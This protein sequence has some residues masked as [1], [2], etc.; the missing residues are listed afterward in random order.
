MYVLYHAGRLPE[1]IADDQE[2]FRNLEILIH[3]RVPPLIRSLPHVESLS[4]FRAEESQ[5]EADV[6]KELGLR[7][8]VPDQPLSTQDT[9]DVVMEE[10]LRN[11]SA[12]TKDTTSATATASSSLPT[13]PPSIP[14]TASIGD[15]KQASV[16]P[17]SVLQP[18][19]E[20]PRLKA[21]ATEST[22]VTP[23]A[24]PQAVVVP[25]QQGLEDEDEEM[26]AINMDS[27]SEEE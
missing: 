21:K 15:A 25:I 5:E 6:R 8:A 22:F 3:P 13:K 10:D 4:L 9:Q 26:P 16:P 23:V 18:P 24:A 7:D 1:L 12:R 17:I 27:D 20:P 19:K 14:S 2:T 11:A